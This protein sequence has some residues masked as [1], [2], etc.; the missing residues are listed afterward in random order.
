MRILCAALLLLALTGCAAEPQPSADAV[1][2][3]GFAKLEVAEAAVPAII[4][5]RAAMAEI[6][7]SPPTDE[8]YV[9]PDAVALI[10][11][12]EVT[13]PAYYSAKLEGVIWPGLHSGVTWGVGYDGGHQTR[14]RIVTDWHEHTY[15]ERLASTA[16]VVGPRAKD[17]L[18]GLAD[19]R[20][21]YPLAVDVFEI[22]TLPTYCRLTERTFK[23]AREL[24]PERAFGAIVA[25]VYNRGV[26]MNGD[27][28]REMKTIRDVCVP[29]G[30]VA[31]LVREFRS[32]PRLWVGTPAENGLRNRYFA[33]AELAGKT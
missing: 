18:P 7:P 27:N 10:V 11:R 3:A 16:G 20:T 2:E 5:V 23:G 33:T 31:C 6:A 25:T 1:I 17:L 13:S 21:P 19:V 22:A 15:V 12:F 14:S 30:D 28:R 8:C 4:D 9:H 24:L 32:M 29:A 26:A